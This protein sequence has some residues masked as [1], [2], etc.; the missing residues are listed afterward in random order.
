MTVP[1][2]KPT[3]K[4]GEYYC[5]YCNAYAHQE[6]NKII[7]HNDDE[8]DSLP[9]YE[10]IPLTRN[11]KAE[12]IVASHSAPPA[13]YLVQNYVP[14]T[15]VESAS[16]SRCSHC[17]QYAFWIKD[18]M[19]YPVVSLAP[20]PSDDMPE[21]VKADYKE[22]ASIV[23]ASPR[24]SSALLRLALQKL[25]PH[26]GEKGKNINEDISNLVNKGLSTDIQQAL[27]LVRVVGNESVHPG[28]F[29]LKDDKET[30]YFLFESLNLIV[31]DTITRKKELDAMY[32]NLPKDKLDG[33]KNRD[34]K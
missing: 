8:V 23:E 20:L 3:Y 26:L 5:P 22:A 33:I 7:H 19:V 17:K 30:A 27:D 29:D 31:Y 16:L 18:K 9:S 2:E 11:N 13:Q 4:K 14:T 21:D 34:K 25:M 24:A 32:N 12:G 1:Y 15:K 6:W 28:V 10:A